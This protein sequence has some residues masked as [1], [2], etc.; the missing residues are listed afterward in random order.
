MIKSYFKLKNARSLLY[1][2]FENDE[3]LS[4]LFI[5]SLNYFIDSFISRP[6]N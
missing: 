3:Q 1:R 4:G 5:D 6:D 2:E